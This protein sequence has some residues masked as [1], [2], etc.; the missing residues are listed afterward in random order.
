VR[1]KIAGIPQDDSYYNEQI[2]PHIDGDRV[3]MLGHVRGAERDKLLGGALALVHMTTRPERFGLTLI[4]AMAC[5]TPVLGAAMGSVPEIVVDGVTGYVCADVDAA[6]ARVPQLAALSRR[7]CRE[8]VQT[9]FSSERMIDRYVDAYIAAIAAGTPPPPT[10]EQQRWR[11][12]DWWDRP[13]AFTDDPP[14]AGR[15]PYTLTVR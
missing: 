1:L 7:A 2:A 10:A 6:V 15:Q 3:Q 12:H 11:E 9:T 13:M 8:H 14:H 5:G 4:E